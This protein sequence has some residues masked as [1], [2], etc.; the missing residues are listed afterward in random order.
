MAVFA[1][2]ISGLNLACT[3]G[4]PVPLAPDDGAYDVLLSSADDLQVQRLRLGSDFRE[5]GPT[6]VWSWKTPDDF[7]TLHRPHGLSV[8][9]D[10][11]LVS[12]FE[13][14]TDAFNVALDLETGRLQQAITTAD[15]SPWGGL[16]EREGER[17][18]HN[19]IADP[20]GGYIASDTHNHRILGLDQ[21]GLLKWEISQSTLWEAGYAQSN[22][23]NPN[24]VELVLIDGETRLLV[25]CRGNEFNHLLWFKPAEPLRS[26]D[27]PWALEGLFPAANTPE[28]LQE[29]HNPQVLED[30][31]GVVVANS[32]HN[33]IE[34]F[35][36]TGESLWRF[37]KE[38]CRDD[39]PLDWPR[40]FDWTPSG[41]LLIA[42][43]S[44][45]RLLEVDLTQDC[46]DEGTLWSLEGVHSTYDV[47]V[48]P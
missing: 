20:S 38:D 16:P 10:R 1:L 27:P 43:S 31:T 13:Y 36:W 44:G 47:V 14:E 35:D 8:D 12:L 40:G 30:G 19:I 46:V 11:V 25:S 24:D 15:G 33:R 3:P 5:Q 18:T 45:D 28:L 21:G 4:L 9:G 17:S 29:N 37:P 48:L 41:T 34:A 42:D 22:F 23:A 26:E 7:D 39:T 6:T 32:F 2:L